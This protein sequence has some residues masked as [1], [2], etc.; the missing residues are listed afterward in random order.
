MPQDIMGQGV[1]LLQICGSTSNTGS[2]VAK[3]GERKS[4]YH[5]GFRAASDQVWC[6]SF[7]HVFSGATWLWTTGGWALPFCVHS[8]G[9]LCI[10]SSAGVECS[11]W[12]E[13]TYDLTTERLGDLCKQTSKN[14]LQGR[15]C[16]LTVKTPPESPISHYKES[17]FESWLQSWSE[18][19]ANMLLARQLMMAPGIPTTYVGQLVEFLTF[20]IRLA[21]TW[22]L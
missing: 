8:W 17:A 7:Q 6:I 2:L 5:A 10:L 19:P 12:T 4:E 13:L 9:I 11:A 3:A 20:T 1:T 16:G 18:L 15:A 21:Q 14:S 22:L